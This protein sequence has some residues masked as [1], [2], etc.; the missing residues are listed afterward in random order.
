MT[1]FRPNPK[2]ILV[3]LNF[4]MSLTF[5]RS[6]SVYHRCIHILIVTTPLSSYSIDMHKGASRPRVQEGILKLEGVTNTVAVK[7]KNTTSHAYA[8]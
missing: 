1:S 8:E 6:E 3:L 7:E 5:A 2:R 4:S